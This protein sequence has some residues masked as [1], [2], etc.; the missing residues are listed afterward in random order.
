MSHPQPVCSRFE[1][2]ATLGSAC[3]HILDL[4]Q[5]PGSLI[6]SSGLVSAGRRRKF[7]EGPGILELLLGKLASQVRTMAS[8][9]S[10]AE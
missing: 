7:S 1:C 5:V 3:G 8:N 4:A 10:V 2:I 9:F 6:L